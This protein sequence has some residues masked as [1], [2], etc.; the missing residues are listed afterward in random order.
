MSRGTTGMLRARP[1]AIHMPIANN[2]YGTPAT[3]MD[4]TSRLVKKLLPHTHATT[5]TRRGSKR[6]TRKNVRGVKVLPHLLPRG[7]DGLPVRRVDRH[8]AAVGGHH[9]GLLSR[10]QQDGLGLAARSCNCYFGALK[11]LSND[12]NSESVRR[13]VADDDLDASARASMQSLR[14]RLPPLAQTLRDTSVLLDLLGASPG[15]ALAINCKSR[16]CPAKR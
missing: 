15:H 1:S 14:S 2:R 7:S 4:S 5:G 11:R 10:R 3:T 8:V 6:E 9:S 16:D 12:R 13:D